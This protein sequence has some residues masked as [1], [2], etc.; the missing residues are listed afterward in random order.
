MG[1]LSFTHVPMAFDDLAPFK[2][3]GLIDEP[4]MLLG[5]DALAIFRQVEIDF[6]SREIL[7]HM[8]SDGVAVRHR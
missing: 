6:A 3:L 8:R 2:T 5:M 4:A 1:G 7:F